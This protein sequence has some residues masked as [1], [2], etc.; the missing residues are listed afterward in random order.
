MV[1]SF[2][3]S[4]IREEASLGWVITKAAFSW[5]YSLD[6]IVQDLTLLTISR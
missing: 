4:N 1:V 2:I 5:L 6:V 3:N